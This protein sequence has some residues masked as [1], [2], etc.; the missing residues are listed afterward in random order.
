[1]FP[2]HPLPSI[3]LASCFRSHQRDNIHTRTYLFQKAPFFGYSAKSL[4]ERLITHWFHTKT[5]RPPKNKMKESGET[6][7]WRFGVPFLG[8]IR[9]EERERRD[10]A[11]S[12]GSSGLCMSFESGG[13]NGQQ[14]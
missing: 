4:V 9:P 14:H 5:L 13:R 3:G 10:G 12:G 2:L 8:L 11:V 7:Y 6:L 1:M